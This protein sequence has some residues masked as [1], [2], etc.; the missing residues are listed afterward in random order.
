MH[1]CIVTTEYLPGP[2]GGV[3][4]YTATMAKFLVKAGHTVTVVVKQEGPDCPW[5]VPDSGPLRVIPVPMINE[6]SG[7]S[8][9]DDPDLYANEMIHLRCY[10]GVFAKKV[11]QRLPEIHAETPIDLVLSQDVEAP[12]YLLQNERMLFNKMAEV[13]FVVFIHSP[14][15]QIQLF[16]DGSLYERH[17][18]HRMLYEEQSM[19]LADGL[20]AASQYMK[21][22]MIAQMGFTEADIRLIPLPLGE[23][24]QGEEKAARSK[25]AEAHRLIYAGRIEPRK[26]VDYLLRAFAK[27]APRYPDLILEL[28]GRDTQHPALGKPCSEV[29]L[30]P[31]PKAIR[32]RIRFLGPVP[33]E[34]LWR[35]YR[36]ADIG[37]VPSL[38]EP[39]S[40]TCQEMMACGLPVVATVEGGMAEMIDS[41][42]HGF[43]CDAHG[44]D[45]LAT[46]LEAALETPAADLKHIGQ[47][48]RQRIFDYCDNTTILE[49]TQSYFEQV[50]EANRDAFKQSHRFTVPSNLPF[51]DHPLSEEHPA[52]RHPTPAKIDRIAVVVTC[53]NL[54]AYL[55]ECIQSLEAQERISPY[56]YIV[57]DGSTETTTLEALD[58]FRSRPCLEVLDFVNGGLPVARRR[59]A[60]IAL[61]AGYPALMFID[62][63]DAIEPSYLRKAVEVLNRHPEAGA[64]NA[65]TH[66]VGLMNTYWIPPHSQFPLLLAECMS[67]P[68]AV[69]RAEAYAA[70]GGVSP[71]MKYAF[72]DWEFWIALCETGYA[73]LTIPEP[74]LRYRMRDGSMSREYRI[75]T[76]EHGRRAILRRHADLH[77]RFS[78]EVQLLTEGYVYFEQAK[79]VDQQ[80]PAENQPPQAPPKKKVPLDKVIYRFFKRRIDRLKKRTG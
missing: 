54:G 62:A 60:E 32:K 72:E 13:P 11:A 69:I 16:N 64:V 28:A 34:Q 27:I 18:Y 26:G 70:A 48:A 73:L 2:G 35:R 25:K 59:G 65:W 24:P 57:N 9:W 61:S 74:L 53:Y 8:I 39:F 79:L 33:R 4:T 37:V 50:I 21:D 31:V 46:S 20:I 10:A 12:T 40:F 80:N 68:A 38:W 45:A 67:T 76:R 17:D 14:H 1:I 55:D 6:A 66:T 58:R 5:P 71:E 42:Q 51:G 30:K 36:K 56:I 41:P 23:V 47:S 29:F 52:K 63:D 43:L 44:V 7:H 22:Q 49:A 78:T 77:R 3:A 15:R 75:A 19:A